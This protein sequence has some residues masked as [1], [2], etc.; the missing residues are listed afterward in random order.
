MATAQSLMD[1]ALRA[2]GALRTG[3]SAAG[4]QQTECLGM[5]NALIDRCSVD[6]LSI[7][8][9]LQTTETLVAGTVSYSVGAGQD[10]DIARPFDIEQT[11]FIRHNDTDYPLVKIS[12]QEYQDIADKTS[13]GLP[14]YIFYDDRHPTAYIYLYPVP[15][16]AYE[17][18]LDHLSP[19]TSYAS[20]E[21]DKS[22]PPAA[23]SFLWTQLA[24]DLWP[25]YPNTEVLAMINR[26]ADNAR[27]PY[28][29]TNV[30]V[31]ILRNQMGGAGC[32]DVVSDR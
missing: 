32:Y 5:L 3:Q 11:S 25:L 19:I 9:I 8:Q 23:E 26:A 17:L 30:R 7:P 21:T 22:L 14:A 10:I 13:Q 24:V 1:R 6:R 27:R 20:A 2:L 15:D 16:Q 31:P 12:R 18:R 28:A 29:Q 4:N